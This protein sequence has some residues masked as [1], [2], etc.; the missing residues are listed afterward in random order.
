[1]RL[2][3]RVFEDGASI[4]KKYTEDGENVSP[5]LVLE[6]VP[7][8]ARSVAIIMD[9]P[10]APRENPWVHWVLY[11]APA[12]VGELPEAIPRHEEISQPFP[13]LQGVNN[14]EKHNIG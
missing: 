3:S 2:R 10:D 12:D 13:A 5:P 14:W 1:M 8:K 11:N 6:D 4:P 7:S 9:D